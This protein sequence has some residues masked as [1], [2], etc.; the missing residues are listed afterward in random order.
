MNARRRSSGGVSR[1]A[2][3][4][5]PAAADLV[6]LARAVL[7]RWGTKGRV[8]PLIVP[9]RTGRAMR[10]GALLPGGGARIAGPTFDEWLAG[11]DIEAVSR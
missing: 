4:A 9:G 1:R 8:V 7:R 3:V 5:G 2:D 6:D 11:P 10:A